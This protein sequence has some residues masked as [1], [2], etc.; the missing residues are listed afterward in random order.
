MKLKKK[1]IAAAIGIGSAMLLA[2]TGCSAPGGDGGDGGD[3]IK[4]GVLA[5][6]EG[7][8]AFGMDE[9][10][11]AIGVAMEARGGTAEGG[12]VAGKKIEFVYAG[13]DG[14]TA[15]AQTQ[16][17]K[18]VENDGVDIVLGPVSG[19]EGETVVQYA[20]TVPE[21]TFVN[22]AASPVGM[23]L[24]GAENF[25]RFHGDSAMWMGGVGTYAHDEKGYEKIYLLAEDY[26]FPYDNAG[27]FFS[28]F[29][30]AGGEI[31]GASWVPV[32]TTD[33]ATIIAQ[34]PA[35]TDAVY[36]GLGGADAAS[37]LSQA[38]TN[39]VSKPLVGGTIAVDTTA[40]S[41]DAN[42]ASAAVGMISGGPV[43]GGDYDT[44]EWDAF[45]AAYATQPNAFPSPSI[46]SILYYNSFES[47]L[48]GLEKADGD[49]SDGQ[50]AFR[51]ALSGLDWTSPTGEIK[52]DENRQAIVTNFMNEVVTDDSGALVLSTVA[53]TDG[54]KQ[55]T[56][57]Y[58]R[59]ES[60]ADLG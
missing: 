49:L 54:V 58:D 1:S 19:D 4:I 26:S 22:G 51:E 41:G 5:T 38:V 15:S 25:F 50:S 40:L 13:T 12:E 24:E 20:L 43:P 3:T 39:G 35:D 23:T 34:I 17:K 10:K 9:A 2:V 47:L 32:G 55:G 37:F 7:N 16:V 45:V 11:A 53:Q 56:T 42:I 30:A 60:C 52:L 36:V 21:V 46:F 44:P 27:G 29:C 18:L 33:Y 57:V 31:T 6:S 28:E 8:L 48:L 14:T 59:F